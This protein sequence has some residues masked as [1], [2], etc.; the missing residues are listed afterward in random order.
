[1][2]T[3]KKTVLLELYDVTKALFQCKKNQIDV[4]IQ[5]HLGKF[6]IYNYD[7]FFYSRF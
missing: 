4:N 2:L 3:I 1:M 6:K 7:S 5:N